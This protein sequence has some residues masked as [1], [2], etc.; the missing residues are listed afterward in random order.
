MIHCACRPV[1]VLIIAL[2]GV[3]GANMVALG[4]AQQPGYLELRLIGKDL[5]AALWKVPAASGRPMAISA[6][7][8]E[9]C[10]PRTPGQLVWDGLAHVT[11]WTAKCPG[12]LEGGM[13]HIEG[14]DRTTTDVLVRFDFADGANQAHRLT[15]S[16][17]FF[18]VAAQP[19]SLDVVQTYSLLGIAHILRGIDHLSFVLATASGEG[20]ME[21]HRH[22]HRFHA[23]P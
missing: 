23:R 14:L 7:L 13:I 2:A 21:D 17:P 19:N 6:Q 1:L 8:P 5:Y 15:A 12:G 4:H 16:D 18:T 11:R 22:R 3:L 9:N 10:D 20:H